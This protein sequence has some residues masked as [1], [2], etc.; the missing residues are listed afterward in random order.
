MLVTKHTRRALWALSLVALALIVSAT[1]LAFGGAGHP[2]TKDHYDRIKEGMKT[3]DVE[4]IIG[5]AAG[6]HSTGAVQFPFCGTGLPRE[7][8]GS[9][10]LCRYTL[11]WLGDEGQLS[12]SFDQDGKVLAKAYTPVWRVDRSPLDRLRAWLGFP[13][14]RRAAPF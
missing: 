2:V 6:D 7:S 12:V 5:I 1:F 3:E 4:R 14:Q 9:S 10:D 11:E 8:Y 13:G